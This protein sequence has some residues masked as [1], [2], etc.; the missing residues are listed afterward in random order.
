MVGQ[1]TTHALDTVRGLGAAGMM[2]RLY[3]LDPD[4]EFVAEVVLDDRGRA[5]VLE[6]GLTAGLYELVFE[7]A[8][9]HRMTGAEISD[10]PFLD[11]VPIRF[12]VAG[13]GSHYHVPLLLTP[14]GYSTYRGS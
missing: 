11:T 5:V 6:D 1:L 14:F 10:P 9:Y 2:V 13:H 7:A 3:R 8:A 4:A 12:G